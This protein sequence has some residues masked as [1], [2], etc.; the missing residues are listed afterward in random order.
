MAMSSVRLL[1]GTRKGAFILTADGKREKWAVSRTSPTSPPTPRCPKRWRPVR[2]HCLLWE[3]LL[4]DNLA[5]E[6]AAFDAMVCL[7]RQWVAMR[8]G[9][10]GGIRV[11]TAYKVPAPR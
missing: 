3:P 11:V 8:D 6:R 9:A 4:A 7:R 10:A 2:S 5:G 1:V